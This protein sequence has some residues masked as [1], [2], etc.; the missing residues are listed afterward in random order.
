MKIGV[1]LDEPKTLSGFNYTFY[2]VRPRN[3][4]I[5]KPLPKAWNLV[6]CFA[7]NTVS[8]SKPGLIAAYKEKGSK[9]NAETFS[10]GEDLPK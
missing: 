7:D 5:L 6:N 9:G 1:L 2:E 10:L 3:G 8:Q 4:R